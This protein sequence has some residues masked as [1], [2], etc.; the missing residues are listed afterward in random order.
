MRWLTNTSPGRHLDHDSFPPLRNPPS[1]SYNPLLSYRTLKDP[2]MAERDLSSLLQKLRTPSAY[3]TT[4]SLLSQ[5]KIA[6]LKLHALTP[7][8]ETPS[9]VLAQAREV[10]EIGALASIRAEDPDAFRRFYYQLT[11]FYELPAARLGPERSDRTKIT[12]LY[13]LL[14]LTTGDYAG[15]HTELEGLQLRAVHD[16]DGRGAAVEDDRFLGYPIKLER[17]LMEGSYDLV[18]KA[19]EGG[20]SLPCEEY[21]VFSSVCFSLFALYTVIILEVYYSCYLSSSHS[22]SNARNR[23]SPPKFATRSLPAAKRP[24][25]PSPSP[26]PKISSFSTL[27]AP[28]SSLRNL[29]GGL[30]ETGG[31]TSPSSRVRVARVWTR[32]IRT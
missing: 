8:E 26:P 1:Y 24:T 3:T 12:G 23:S 29:E 19:M 28:S 31:Y 16:G 4:L 25:R 9:A 30:S 7:R 20:Q 2:K 6:L 17:W 13:L 18:W 14:L 5:A 27:K 21:G 22:S 11:P 10:Y 15:F 32:S